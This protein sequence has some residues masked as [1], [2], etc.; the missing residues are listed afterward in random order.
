[1]SK[2]KK[3]I[4]ILLLCT[5]I[6]PQ[7][8]LFTDAAQMTTGDVTEALEYYRLNVYK[9]DWYWDGG[10]IYTSYPSPVCRSSNC[11]CNTFYG[12]SQCHGFALCLAYLVTG[13]AP[14]RTL[15]TYVN[16]ATSNGWTCYTRSAL[17]T[18]GILAV[19]LQPGDIV[20]AAT[21]S[22]YSNG[23]TALVWKI[24][25]GSVY[26]GECW[27]SRHCKLNWGGFNYYY[28]T[29]ADICTRYGYVAI[30]RKSDVV[31]G[32]STSVCDHNY[33]D[34]W[35]AEHPH[36]AYKI[37]TKCGD[38][39]YTGENKKLDDC[40]CCLG[41]HSWIYS[42]EDAHPHREVRICSVCGQ[43]E[44]TG[45]TADFVESCAECAL[46]PY[47]M[48]V[49]ISE[50]E[51]SP[52]H[53]VRLTASAK[54]CDSFNVEI[55]RDGML[56]ET[57]VDSDFTDGSVDL[58]LDELGVYNFRMNAK[59]QSERTQT[60]GQSLTVALHVVQ[61]EEEVDS[62]RIVY[63]DKLPSTLAS[64]FCSER[65][66]TL[67]SMSANGFTLIISSA[68]D[69]GTVSAGSGYRLIPG[70]FSWQEARDIAVLLGGDLVSVGDTLENNVVTGLLIA[71]GVKS[72]WIGANDLEYE[73]SWAWSSGDK[74][75]YTNWSAAHG[76]EYDPVQNW[77]RIFRS[78]EWCE[79]S[80]SQGADGF[81]IEYG[82]EFVTR[83][84][85]GGVAIT[86]NNAMSA[87][88]PG[89]AVV[90]SS[91]GGKTVVALAP[92]AFAGMELEYVI[93]PGTL[94]QIDEG[95]LP[96]SAAIYAPRDGATAPLLNSL[97]VE[98][99]VI[100][101]FTDLV[102]DSWYYNAAR[103]CYENGYLSGTSDT[104]FSPSQATTRAMLVTILA[105]MAHADLSGYSNASSF[106]D[107]ETGKWYSAAVEW[108]YQNGIAAGYAGNFNVKNKLTREQLAV[109]M[110]AF[111]E[112]DGESTGIDDPA[113]LLSAY[114]D[115]DEISA[116]AAEAVAWAIDR[117]LISGTSSDSVSP[118]ST[119]TR[120][121]IS[122]II[123]KYYAEKYKNR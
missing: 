86:G 97:G 38:M 68:S 91:I 65:G 26:F 85:D 106:G 117:G 115:A 16:G 19:G 96:Q 49:E 89:G 100:I 55:L 118:G 84:V 109:F 8:A 62:T 58:T 31:P 17:G 87:N 44:Y 83:D 50:S 43:R 52:G 53:T 29:L 48:N 41:I 23:H 102:Q 61:A 2:I 34:G 77:A 81:I 71:S 12:A 79:S 47:A 78:G 70:G 76:E 114:R 4:S 112:Y 11:T 57:L 101:P 36:A 54:N 111:A 33:V 98:W 32:V 67:E 82:L 42:Y 74:M 105:S 99:E 95:A 37:C 6:L 24:E 9:Q 3:L 63:S 113:E 20:R 30:W 92:G 75:N 40:D 35:D 120:A 103:F 93:L 56:Y 107:V 104:T 25:N 1:M 13:S 15:A 80:V 51:I 73:G 94:L 21:D 18:Q 46:R 5:L 110:R 27:G 116:W 108:A 121:Q 45:A 69:A 28:Y 64:K 7:S 14:R 39:Y 123:M 10:D 72:A 88:V 119:A 59:K 22:A 66:G 90:P 60:F 122:V